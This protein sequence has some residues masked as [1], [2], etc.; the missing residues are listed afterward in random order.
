MT[1][2]RARSAVEGRGPEPG[3]LLV[4]DL[5]TALAMPKRTT[6]SAVRGT[7]NP[8]RVRAATLEASVKLFAERGFAGT[9]FQNISDACG[10]SVGLI[11]Y[12]FGSK[13]Q[14]Y[15]AVK[16]HAIDAYVAS[17][18]PQF[19]MPVGDLF[20]FLDAGLRQYFRF[21][22]DQS[23]WPRLSAWAQLEGDE[24]AWPG[25][26]RLLDHL[27]ERFSASQRAGQLRK[28]VDPEL[29]SILLGGLMQGWLRYGKRYASR[30]SH[31]GDAPAREDAYMRFCLD[32][33][34]R[35]VGPS[36]SPDGAARRTPA[37]RR[38]KKRTRPR[39]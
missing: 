25:E 35:S 11:Q 23:V 22:E 5:L 27:I 33:L 17:Q 18:E 21:F 12:H 2:G 37:R 4:R 32:V 14:L 28:D 6:H 3:C 19:Q 9:S 1:P 34:R 31:L 8:E 29:F 16:E 36:T 10:V 20:A 15:E 7:R 13:E 26:H 39:E 30:L 24:R 38:A